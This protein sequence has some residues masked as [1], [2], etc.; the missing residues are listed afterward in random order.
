MMELPSLGS[1]LSLFWT[2][3]LAA[4]GCAIAI[5]AARENRRESDVV[6]RLN[7]KPSFTP[8]TTLHTPDEFSSTKMVDN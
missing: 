6:S 4:M 2:L 3:F 1:V 5:W 7:C 8:Q